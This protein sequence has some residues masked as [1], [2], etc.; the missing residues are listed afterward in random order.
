[1]TITLYGTSLEI[2]IYYY[3]STTYYKTKI[4]KYLESRF[5]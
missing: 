1:L 3:T 4:K 2:S 5:R